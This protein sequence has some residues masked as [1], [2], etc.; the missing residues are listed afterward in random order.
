MPQFR[1]KQRR[2][3]ERGIFYKKPKSVKKLLVDVTNTLKKAYALKRDPFNFAPYSRLNEN[4]DKKRHK[5][6]DARLWKR[7][8]GGK[9]LTYKYTE[10]G[11]NEEK[12]KRLKYY[13]DLLDSA[14][15]TMPPT[16]PV[17]TPDVQMGEPTQTNLWPTRGQPYVGGSS[18]ADALMQEADKPPTI[19]HNHHYPPMRIKQSKRVNNPFRLSP[20]K[21]PAFRRIKK[22]NPFYLKKRVRFARKAITY[23]YS[24]KR[25][26]YKY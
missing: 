8:M 3:S 6:Q 9:P 26:R 1:Y 21:R 13:L 12:A 24:A 16:V 7:K 20:K 19:V 17:V 5:Q 4:R 15:S 11:S 2:P 22:V 18:L 23:K 14:R 10:P 25:R